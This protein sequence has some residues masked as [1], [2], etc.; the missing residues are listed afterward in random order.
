MLF[1]MQKH[2]PQALGEGLLRRVRENRPLFYGADDILAAAGFAIEDDTMLNI[3]L[4]ETNRHDQRADAA[5]SVLGPQAVGKL[6]EAYLAARKL[7]RNAGKYDKA[8]DDRCYNLRA[9]IGHTPGASLIAAVQAR[10]AT[11][12]NE[13]IT[14]LAELLCREAYGAEGPRPGLQ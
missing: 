12:D 2:F 10:A 14:E 7:M 3:A 8:A 13:E 9:R 11:R 1:E 5:A 4:E 6:I